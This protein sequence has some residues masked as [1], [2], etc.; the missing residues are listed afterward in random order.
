MSV[1]NQESAGSRFG[2]MSNI[3]HFG[4]VP[5]VSVGH[6]Y[7]H[8]QRAEQTSFFC[9]F[10]LTVCGLVEL[11]DT[12]EPRFNGHASVMFEVYPPG[13]AHVSSISHDRLRG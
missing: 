1:C 10:F 4:L 11:S 7:T 9:L 12:I 5:M 6:Q 2:L 8:Q 13:R 3:F